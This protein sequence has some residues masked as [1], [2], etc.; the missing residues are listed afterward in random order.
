MKLSDIKKSSF[1]ALKI[2][3]QSA[4]EN[5]VEAFNSKVSSMSTKRNVSMDAKELID[6]MDNVRVKLQ[7][8]MEESKH[9]LLDELY[10]QPYISKTFENKNPIQLEDMEVICFYYDD[11]IPSYKAKSKD[12]DMVTSRY[13]TLA[14]TRQ[15]AELKGFTLTDNNILYIEH[16]FKDKRSRDLDNRNRK[17]LIDALKYNNIIN[18]DNMSN[19]SIFEHGKEGQP[20]NETLVFLL[21]EDD[22]LRFYDLWR[23]TKTTEISE[24]I[25]Q[26]RIALKTFQNEIKIP[27]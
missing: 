20:T 17:L 24:E 21:K 4:I 25:E 22:F 11:V 27:E 15:L 1:D 7:L 2:V 8:F 10:P 16:R 6:S 12:K 18:D 19:L 9:N 14:T 23:K 26:R 3:G 5:A 13:F